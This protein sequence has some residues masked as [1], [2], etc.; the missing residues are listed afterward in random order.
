M[1]KKKK[2]IEYKKKYKE[3]KKDLDFNQLSNTRMYLRRCR[4]CSCLY[5]TFYK[6]SKKCK[7]CCNPKSLKI[8]AKEYEEI[9]EN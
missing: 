9:V 5:K 7:N 4:V 6:S 1:V 3:A 8:Y 2:K